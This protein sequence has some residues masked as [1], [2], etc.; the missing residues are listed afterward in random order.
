VA[1]FEVLIRELT[2][3]STATLATM[4]DQAFGIFNNVSPRFQWAE[5]DLPFPSDE[6][7][8]QLTN[9]DDLVAQSLHPQNKMKIKDA[10]LVLFAP[11][12][13]AEEDL[14]VLRSG[15]LT[16]HDMQ[17]LM[18]CK[19]I[20][21]NVSISHKNQANAIQDLYTHVWKCTFSNPM[22]GLP[23]TNIPGLLLP[24]KIAMRNWRI[25]WNQIKGSMPDNEWNK[26]GFERTA[27]T[28]FDAVKAIV[29]A[30]EKRN[31]KFP[32]IPSDCEKGTHLKRLL[33]F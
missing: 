9:Y 19:P 17:M 31:G 8:F 14:K 7:Y 33:M 2:F 10:F 18:H 29:E 21:P 3:A 16:A 20:F 30:F 25:V 5:L 12:E 26:L 13:T 11:P 22:V 6:V 15:N 23:I 4:L 24:F 32:P 28:Y 1:F 27:E